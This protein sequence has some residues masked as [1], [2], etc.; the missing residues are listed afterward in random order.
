MR[1]NGGEGTPPTVGAGAV[2]ETEE[3]ST[4]QSMDLH[5]RGAACVQARIQCRE[6]AS[7]A[8]AFGGVALT[9]IVMPLTCHKSG[10]G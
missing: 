2:G 7:R 9:Q 5:V 6:S 4:A 1:W 3:L 8:I 10:L